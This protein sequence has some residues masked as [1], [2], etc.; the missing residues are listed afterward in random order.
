MK[1]NGIN[2][3]KINCQLSL[4]THISRIYPSTVSVY[5]NFIQAIFEKYIL[6]TT[7]KELNHST[8]INYH[9]LNISTEES[10]ILKVSLNPL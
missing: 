7:N 4:Y 6:T 3:Y 10:K 1:I 8:I 2:F 9:K 5:R